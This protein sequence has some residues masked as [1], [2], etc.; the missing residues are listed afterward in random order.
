MGSVPAQTVE[1]GRSA[2]VNVSQYFSDPDGDALAYSATSSNSNVAR[3]SVS[4]FTATI[5]AAGA[6][7]TTVTVTAR[8]PEGLS[9]T[10]QLAVTVPN[11][12]PSR[13]GSVPAQT[14]EVGRSATVNVSP[15][16]SD[17]DGDA[18]AYSATSSNT[19]VARASVSGSTVT[20]AAA[21]AGSTTITVTASDPEG[22][23][24]TQQLSV[25]VSNRPPR[26]VGSIPGQ[27]VD[28]GQSTTVDL[29]PYFSDP[30]RDPL[31]YSATSQDSNV[32]R[33]SVS[34]STVT[35]TAAGAGSTTVTVTARDPE[36]LSA[37]QQF[38]VTVLQP[39]RAP[40]PQGSIPG[41]TVDVGQSTTVDLSPYF[42]DPD[43]D[44]LAYSATSSNTNVARASVSG[45][46]VT[47]AAASAGSTTI[48]VTASD[49]EGLTATQ[50]VR[51]TVPEP[52][53][54]PRPLG[55]IPAHTIEV[56]QSATVNAGPYFT[57]PDGDVLT[58]SA[59]SSDVGIATAEVFG[60]VIEFSGVSAGQAT[61]TVTATDPWGLSATLGLQVTVTAGETGSFHIDLRFATSMTATQRA[62]FESARARWMAILA[63]TELPDMPVPEGV[64]RCR[65]S[66]RTYE[67]AVSV[68]DDLMISAAV[69]E[70]D[71]VDGTLGN[72]GFCGIR[73]Q[74]QLPWYGIMQFD[75]ADLEAMETN[76]T[77]ESV[78][79]HEMGH[80]LGIGTLWGYLGLLR[81]PSLEA[82]REVDTFLPLPLAV[83]AFDQAG[84]VGYTAGGKVPVENS[85]TRPGSDDGH[86]RESVFGQELMVWAIAPGTSP[87]L[88]AVTIAS[89]ADLGY[90]VRMNLADSYRLPDAAALRIHRMHAIHLGNDVLRIPIEVRDQN[91]RVVRI[92]RP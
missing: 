36:G 79:L 8:D 68:V 53:R 91:G 80:V 62:A 78:I 61:I 27:T 21:S 18:L 24:A 12:P 14:V 15:Y 84:G 37:T 63:D 88:S 47:I 74:P 45:S 54:A 43:G 92:I 87:P 41:Q 10:Q 48:T 29:S 25:T 49:P 19:N 20:I 58:F 28:L 83:G 67:E 22:L 73:D 77:L 42:S 57:D 34:G 90:T 64:V 31:E 66:I 76:G 26:R 65:T 89:L 71:G 13:V 69:V 70:I 40:R 52:N 11:R 1:V 85:G 32:A 35:I 82:G 72:A 81:N 44:A 38:A 50:Q 86:W 60:E 30:D 16:F 39:N 6:G 46:T 4:G 2:T 3:A 55:S 33:A 9:A 23:T 7:S 59:S 51:V 17:P 56:G 5:T 75:A